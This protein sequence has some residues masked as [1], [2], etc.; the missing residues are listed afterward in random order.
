MSPRMVVQDFLLWLPFWLLLSP[1]FLQDSISSLPPI[2]FS[3]FF[4]SLFRFLSLSHIFLALML[5]R[6][7]FEHHDRSTPTDLLFPS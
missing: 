1:P 3:L 5:S 4:L 7:V 6:I 2:F